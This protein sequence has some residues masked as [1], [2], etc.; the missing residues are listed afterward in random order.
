MCARERAWP[1][2]ADTPAICLDLETLRHNLD[3]LS[4]AAKSTQLPWLSEFS[5]HH[6]PQL[7]LLELATGASATRVATLRDA[8][9]CAAAGITDMLLTQPVV[10]PAQLERLM[11]LRLRTNVEVT[12]DH[13]AQAAPLAAILTQQRLSCGVWVEMNVGLDR[14][15]IRA[16]WDTLDLIKGLRTLPGINLR[17]VWVNVD[18]GPVTSLAR[19]IDQLPSASSAVNCL[20]DLRHRAVELGQQLSLACR[21]SLFE[22]AENLRDDPDGQQFPRVLTH[23]FPTEN[24]LGNDLTPADTP[25]TFVAH[26]SLQPAARVIATVTSRPRLERAVLDVGL[27]HTGPLTHLSAVTH[28]HSGRCLG[29]TKVIEQTADSTIVELLG[30]DAFDLLIGEQVI[31]NVDSLHFAWQSFSSVQVV[32]HGRVV[33]VWSITRD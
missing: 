20:Q 9:A 25:S 23:C 24:V 17:G 10:G 14:S 29:V 5:H 7:A 19:E 12:V 2:A 11:Q 6:C 26:N 8:E 32:D 27:K 18:P 31:V 21:G 30:P 3:C 28:T 13:F 4:A 1:A 15:G 22:L 33:D 16:G